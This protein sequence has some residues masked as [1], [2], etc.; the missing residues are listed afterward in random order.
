M[1]VLYVERG[2]QPDD[3]RSLLHG[4][5]PVLARAH[6][7]PR[8]TVVGRELRQSRERRSRRLRIGAERRHC[9]QPHDAHRAALDEL[10]QLSRRHPALALLARDV[11]LDKH[12]GLVRAV[13]PQLIQRRV[14]GDRMN[15]PHQRQDALDL[16]ALDVADEVPCEGI[17]PALPL[18]LQIL[19][20]VLPDELHAGLGQRPHL[21]ERDVLRRHEDLHLGADSIPYPLE[22]AP[23]APALQAMDEP[24]H[25]PRLQTRPACRPVRPPSRRWEKKS[26]GWQLVHRS[27]ISTRSTPAWASRRRATSRRSSIRPAAMP[28]P[29]E[30]NASRTSSPTS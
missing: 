8:Q 9:Y 2:T 15:Q 11:D 27:L 21:L 4:D 3:G 18:C 22:V 1:H 19:K 6:R 7:E 30:P 24:G 20:A 17:S 16:P 26:S 13:P 10:A 5:L 25:Q 29:S 28:S 12:L 14:T 23:D